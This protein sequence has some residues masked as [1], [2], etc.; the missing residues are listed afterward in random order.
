MMGLPC[1]EPTYVYGD[2]QSVFA[3]TS[4]PASQ[5]KEKPK[6]ITYHYVREGCAQDEWR[7][8]YV[9]MYDNTANLVTKALPSGEKLWKFV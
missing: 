7:T 4:T 5:L 3:N 2:N 1:Y 9:N 8:T 6:S